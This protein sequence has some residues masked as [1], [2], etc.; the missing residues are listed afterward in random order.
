MG[1]VHQS[2]LFHSSLLQ[3][4]GVISRIPKHLDMT[5]RTDILRIIDRGKVSYS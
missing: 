2:K 1:A 3:F 4:A 5:N